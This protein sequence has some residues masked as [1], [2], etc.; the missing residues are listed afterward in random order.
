MKKLGLGLLLIFFALVADAQKITWTYSAKKI[1]G[2]K[3]ELHLIANPPVGWHI[4]SQTTPDGGPV[5]T[6]FTFNKNA[7]VTVTGTVKEKGKL[8]TYYD[9]NFKVNVK[10]FE[11]KVDFVQVVTIKGKIKTNVSGE[12]ESMICND[13]TCMPPTSE[14]F[15]IALN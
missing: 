4:Y 14:K 11:G 3:Y 5:P 7:L 2:D 9:K 13:R 10:Y 15:N 1:A 12:I 8:V 6:T